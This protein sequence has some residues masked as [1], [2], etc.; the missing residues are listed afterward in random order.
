MRHLEAVRP[1][2]IEPNRT[3]SLKQH[4]YRM[5]QLSQVIRLLIRIDHDLQC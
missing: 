1:T 5:T 4:A 2:Q 3:S